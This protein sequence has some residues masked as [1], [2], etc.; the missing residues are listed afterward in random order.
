VINDS[1]VPLE[2]TSSITDSN[3]ENV[4]DNFDLVLGMFFI[5]SLTGAVLSLYQVLGIFCFD[6]LLKIS[7][8]V[9]IFNKLNLVFGAGCM[10]FMHY[11]R[12]RHGGRVCSGDYLDDGTIVANSGLYLLERG[13]LMWWYIVTFWSI[14]GLVFVV[15]LGITIATI[16]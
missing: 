15:A 7:Y 13:D 12:F 4:S 10:F 11:Y 16:R 5:Q 8:P 1:D 3:V 9:G 14:I 6:V 2:T